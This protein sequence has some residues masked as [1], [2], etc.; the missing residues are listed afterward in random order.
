MWLSLVLAAAVLA[1]VFLAEAALKTDFRCVLQAPSIYHPMGTDALG[2]DLFARVLLGSGVSLGVGFGAVAIAFVI[3]LWIGALSGYYEGFTDRLL[4]GTA[5][6]FLCFPTIF[7]ILG[8]IAVLGPS[9]VHVVWILG[10]TAW[11]GPARLVRAEILSLK[12]RE[13]VMASRAMGGNDLW[14]LWRHLIPNAMGPVIVNAI[15][16]LAGAILTETGL[17]FL[18]LGVQPPMPSWG[19]I[20]MDAKSTAQVAWW[21]MFF[22]GLMI[23]LTVVSANTVAEK[24]KQRFKC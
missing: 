16:A 14:I 19:N 2:R 10:L 23:F 9:A 17:S 4:M 13:F 11:M 18:G 21:Q 6:V 12:T 1:P 7:L 24:A 22:P 5:N 15:L 8:V 20:L 3:G